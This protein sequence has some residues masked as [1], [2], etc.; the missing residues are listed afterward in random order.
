MK[1]NKNKCSILYKLGTIFR[2]IFIYVIYNIK[3]IIEFVSYFATLHLKKKERVLSKD[4]GKFV[5]DDKSFT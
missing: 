5:D 2:I 3:F 1:Q 4:Y